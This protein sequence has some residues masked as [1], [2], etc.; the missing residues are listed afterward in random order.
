MASS[1]ALQLLSDTRER[2]SG[3]FMEFPVPKHWQLH[4]AGARIMNVAAKSKAEKTASTQALPGA[5]G[6]LAALRRGNLT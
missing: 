2:G 4:R 6:I 1:A 5:D 3:G